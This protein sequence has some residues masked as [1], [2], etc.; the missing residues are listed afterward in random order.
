MAR[1]FL[2]DSWKDPGQLLP[3]LWQEDAPN[4]CRDTLHISPIH[5]RTPKYSSCQLTRVHYSGLRVFTPTLSFLT[6]A[7]VGSSTHTPVHLRFTLHVPIYKN[8]RTFH[9]PHGRRHFN[10]LTLTSHAHSGGRARHSFPILIRAHPTGSSMSTPRSGLPLG[11]RPGQS[12]AATSQGVSHGL[13]GAGWGA[14]LVNRCWAP[15]IVRY[16]HGASLGT[17]DPCRLPCS[18]GPPWWRRRDGGLTHGSTPATQPAAPPTTRLGLNT[19]EAG[20]P[21]GASQ[22]RGGG[23]IGGG[24]SQCPRPLPL[25]KTGVRAEWLTALHGRGSARDWLLW[26]LCVASGGS[27]WLL[28]LFC[29]GEENK[30]SPP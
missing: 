6:H 2:G 26:R 30:M 24:D 18:A 10:F 12:G 27:L 4:P 29:P 11:L 17:P 15:R 8:P 21:C 1:A 3:C 22:E 23:R 13:Q 9:I 28:G 20:T 5:T 7:A 16:P 19:S 25:V 14:G